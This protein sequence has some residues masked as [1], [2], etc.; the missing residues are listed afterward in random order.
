MQKAALLSAAIGIV[1]TPA[2]SRADSAAPPLRVI[3]P[4]FSQLV[5]F[6][7]PADF[8][9]I[10]E[11]SNGPGYIREAVLK[12]ETP[13]RWTQMITVTGAKGAAAKRAVSPQ[14][15]AGSIAGGFK[16]ACPR[17][18]AAKALGE[19]RFGDHTA[20]VTVAGCGRVDGSDDNHSETALIAVVKGNSDYYTLQWAERSAQMDSPAIDDA[21]WTERM[22]L[23]QPIRLCPILSGEAAPYPSCGGKDQP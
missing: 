8:V 16:A 4:I 22:R 13:D 23:L 3:S 6:S 18:F 1:F 11:G 17:T 19:T 7:M 5:M 14:T 10:T 12:G 15:F 2:A 9:A 21:K 20:F